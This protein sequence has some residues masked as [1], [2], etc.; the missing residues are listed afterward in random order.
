MIIKLNRFNDKNKNMTN[1]IIIILVIFLFIINLVYTRTMV[2]ELKIRN[3]QIQSNIESVRKNTNRFLDILDERLDH[4]HKSFIKELET[5]NESSE[6][7]IKHYS[8]VLTLLDD[9]K[10]SS[11]T[12]VKSLNKKNDELE[13]HFN[14]LLDVLNCKLNIV[15]EKLNHFKIN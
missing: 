13:N 1:L 14:K 15:Q 7:R 6:A 11:I 9:L 12:D 5:E 8:K 2:Y 4:L 3:N 10:E